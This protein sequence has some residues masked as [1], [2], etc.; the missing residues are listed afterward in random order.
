MK[1]LWMALCAAVCASNAF[2]S[3]SLSPGGALG[4][5]FPDQF[6]D[7]ST[8]SSLSDVEAR[9]AFIGH[10]F[11]EIDLTPSFALVPAI[12]FAMRGSERNR[13]GIDETYRINYLTM[14][15]WFKFKYFMG[16]IMPFLAAGPNV[17]VRL[18]A[19]KQTQIFASG[20]VSSVTDDIKD[21]TKP[22]D[23][24]ADFL[25]GADYDAGFL[26]PFLQAGYYVGFLNSLDN[27]SGDASLRNIGFFV[28]TGLRFN[29]SK[30]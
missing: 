6:I 19:K 21:E 4:V 13:T 18:S 20:L 14:P 7:D 3:L 24:G 2:A 8:G 15:V 12:G 10:A 16:R 28:Q 1:M 5:S 9:T 17:A 27:P 30:R 29:L 23:I 22:V 25:G 26:V 11:L